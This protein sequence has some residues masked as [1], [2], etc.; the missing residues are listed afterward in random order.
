MKVL[1]MKTLRHGL[2]A[3]LLAA[4]SGCSDDSGVDPFAGPVPAQCSATSL[5]PSA[6]RPSGA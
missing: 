6:T 5:E 3:A 2:L 4:S 1:R